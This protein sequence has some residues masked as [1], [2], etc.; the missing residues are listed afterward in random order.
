MPVTPHSIEVFFSTTETPIQAVDEEL[1]AKK[2]I[3]LSV[4]RED[5]LHEHISGN[6]FRKL[7]HQLIEAARNKIETLISFGG[8]YSNHLV[9]LA[10]A[11]KQFGFR[12]IAVVRGDE[13]QHKPLNPSLVFC[14]DCG[15]QLNFVSREQYRQKEQGDIITELKKV[16]PNSLIIPEGGT[17]MLAVQGCAEILT[18]KHLHF[19]V[20]ACSVGTGGTIA[21]IISA[22]K[23]HQTI[24]GFSALKGDFLL[25]TVNKLISS[26]KAQWQITDEYS[27]G[28]YAKTPLV[29]M[30]FIDRFYQQHKLLLEP[31]Y[32]G[33]MLF[34]IYDLVD[35]D[36]FSP[37]TKILAIHS[38]GLQGWKG[39]EHKMLYIS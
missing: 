21:G 36:Y 39:F 22:A 5:L 11:G 15:M 13:L 3:S 28:G 32:T 4:L 7:K 37:G 1:F 31:I 14:R 17:N 24:I 33:K 9:A 8:A 6:K 19:D 16:Y 10:Y 27:F 18:E 25:D 29:L 38:G 23:D 2:N 35:R 30:D 34:G 12:T 26:S 20:I